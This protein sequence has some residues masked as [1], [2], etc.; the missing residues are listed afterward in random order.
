MPEVVEKPLL[1]RLPVAITFELVENVGVDT[2]TFKLKID[3]EYVGCLSSLDL[4]AKIKEKF[5]SLQYTQFRNVR[6]PD[7][8]NATGIWELHAHGDAEIND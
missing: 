6:E 2:S 7:D 5:G 4:S 3:G 1:K 8:I